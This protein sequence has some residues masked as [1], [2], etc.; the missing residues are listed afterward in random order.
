MNLGP[1]SMQALRVLIH[2]FLLTLFACRPQSDPPAEVFRSFEQALK[3][4]DMQSLDSLV[5]SGTREYFR[6]LQPWII[7]GDEDSLPSL[8]P[9]DQYLIYLIRMHLDALEKLEW[10]AWLDGLQTQPSPNALSGYLLEILEESFFRASLGEVDTYAGVTAG[11]LYRLRSDTGLRV[12]FKNEDG[13][14]IDLRNFLQEHFKQEIKPYLTDR[15]K[16]RDRVWEMLREK[17]GDRVNSNLKTSRVARQSIVPV[18]IKS[19]E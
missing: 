2:L 6:A 19:Y 3:T 17:Y 15:Y 14:K 9:F 7:V 5:D 1:N 12:R 16:N 4:S 13:W 18:D 10:K 8:N 11:P